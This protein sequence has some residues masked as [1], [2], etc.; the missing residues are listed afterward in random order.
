MKIFVCLLIL[1][2]VVSFAIDTGDKPN[3]AH[4]EDD[5]F[6]E[7]KIEKYFPLKKEL[8]IM[9]FEELLGRIKKDKPSL[10]FK[11]SLM[12][13]NS[14][15]HFSVLIVGYLNNVVNENK[16]E[17]VSQSLAF[18][19]W[20]EKIFTSDDKKTIK[21]L[22]IE[23]LEPDENH[24]LGKNVH[25][26]SLYDL[27]DSKHVLKVFERAENQV[28]GYVNKLLG[29]NIK[30]DPTLKTCAIKRDFAKECALKYFDT[31]CDL[32]I[33]KQEI[34]RAR[35]K[36]PPFWIRWT[37]FLS[38][39]FNPIEKIMEKCDLNGDQVID[40]K[41]F[42]DPRSRC[43]DTCDSLE[44]LKKYFCDPAE[45]EF[46]NNVRANNTMGNCHNI[47]NGVIILPPLPN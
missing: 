13:A 22:G 21:M 38:R 17:E 15:S 36:Y 37:K 41:E 26:R 19:F 14:F 12:F 33:D 25:S 11:N 30:D 6:F 7:R 42:F 46:I 32:K 44:K 47:V 20:L 27:P 39:F 4:T 31:N 34:I 2:L 29:R 35:D 18:L 40:F 3:P 24:P 28:K 5:I 23:S 16:Q 45:K 9:Q 43:L 8:T 1:F 10:P